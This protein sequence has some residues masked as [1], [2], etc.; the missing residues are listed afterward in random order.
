MFRQ[1]G[2]LLPDGSRFLIGDRFSAADLTFAALAAPVLLP[3]G[4]RAVQPT[5]DDVPA[6]M[7]EEILHLRETDAGRFA[8]R[9]FSEE[10]DRSVTDI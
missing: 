8:L 9:M 5:L 10:R 2:E 7:R 1:V 3:V 4:C 6:T